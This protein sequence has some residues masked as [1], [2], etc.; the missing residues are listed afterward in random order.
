MWLKV[1]NLWIKVARTKPWRSSSE[2]TSSDSQDIGESSE[3]IRNI[4]QID[5]QIYDEPQDAPIITDNPSDLR[6]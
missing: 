2:Y 5:Q 3:Y 1:S 6:R 4:A